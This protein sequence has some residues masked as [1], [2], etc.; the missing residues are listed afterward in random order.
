MSEIEND[1]KKA[2]T[3]DDYS[4]NVK[5]LKVKLMNAQN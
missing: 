4:R 2:K 3:K 1:S 5:K